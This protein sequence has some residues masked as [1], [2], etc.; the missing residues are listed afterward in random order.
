MIWLY[1]EKKKLENGYKRSKLKKMVNKKKSNKYWM[2]HYS[3]IL[4]PNNPHINFL[5]LYYHLLP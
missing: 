1:Q 4:V 3:N 2:K 5:G